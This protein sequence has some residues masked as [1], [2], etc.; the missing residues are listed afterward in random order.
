MENAAQP[1]LA[2]IW[3]KLYAIDCQESTKKK[4]GLTYLSWNAA[5]DGELSSGAF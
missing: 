2:E 3:S 5:C 1:T 4:N